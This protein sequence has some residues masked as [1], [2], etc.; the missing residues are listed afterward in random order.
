M[1]HESPPYLMSPHAM[2]NGEANP[3]SLLIQFP[4]M[5]IDI[6]ARTEWSLCML[7]VVPLLPAFLAPFA[8][9]A[10]TV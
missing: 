6:S 10:H 4:G 9:T 8:T 5:F 2:I 3:G 7:A 1:N